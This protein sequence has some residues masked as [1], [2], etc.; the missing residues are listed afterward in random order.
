M[1]VVTPIESELQALLKFLYMAPVGVVQTA[2]NGDITI[3]N[4]MAANLLMPL[5]ADGTLTN[6][7]TALDHCVPEIEKI[8]SNHTAPAGRIFSALRFSPFF[9]AR[10]HAEQKT[11]EL[12]LLKVDAATL[13]AVI[14]DVTDAVRREEQ[15]RLGAAW[16]NAL[17]NDR[18]DYGV[19]ALD[20]NGTVL[21]W[22]PAMEKLTGSSGSDVIGKPVSALFAK[23]S[24]VLRSLPDLL[25]EATQGGW[26]LQNAWCSTVSGKPFWASYIIFTSDK[27][28]PESNEQQISINEQSAY[29]LTIRDM[30]NHVDAAS[31]IMHATYSDHLTGITNRRAFF[32]AAEIEIKRWRRV[33]RPLCLLAVDA[34]HFKSIND[35]FGHSVGDAVLKALAMA[36]KDSVRQSDITARIGGEE[37]AVMLPHTDMTAACELAERL[38]KNVEALEI[39]PDNGKAMLCLTVSIGIAQMSTD[40]SDIGGLMDLADRALYVAKNSGRNRVEPAQL[41]P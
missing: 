23:E 1:E 24:N 18:F 30:N 34:D 32:D 7:F 33:P 37:F 13:M 26:T 28:A 16:Y 17:L 27:T 29:M 21:N 5:Q 3:I 2:L 38:R 14:N 22:N 40:L 8:A 4:P 10:R 19:V 31:Q 15:L 41:A 20:N 35:E 39:M 9:R 25:Y 11:F 12:T 36:I 6:L